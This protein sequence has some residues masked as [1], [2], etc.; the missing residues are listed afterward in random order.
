M[1]KIKHNKYRSTGI[2]FELLIRQITSDAIAGKDSPA[3]SLIKKYFSKTEL[4]KEHKIYQTLI[5]SK[6]LNEAKA[7]IL[8]NTS[9]DMSSRL[10]KSTLRRE[11]YNLIKEIKEGYNLE[12]F[13]QAKVNNYTQ[14]ASIY[15]LIESHDSKSFINPKEV[16]DNRVTLLEYLTHNDIDKN[17]TEDRLL[18]EYSN[19]DKGNRMLIYSVLLEKFNTKYEVLNT[20]QKGILKEYIINMSNSVALREFVNKHYVILKEKL[21][22][23]INKVEDKTIKIKLNEVVNLL[24]PLDKKENVKDENVISLLQ[25]YQLVNEL[26]K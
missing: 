21:S 10:N 25:Y 5:S 19:L 13:F 9:L 1:H 12:E 24:K 23:H 4:A 7:D 2:L 15:N 18:E 16:I 6:Q 17:I 8:I 14:Y 3:V 11:K 20:E 26:N 22:K